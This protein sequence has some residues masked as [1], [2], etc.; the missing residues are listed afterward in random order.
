[1]RE[2]PAFSMDGAARILFF[3]SVRDEGML[4]ALR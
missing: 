3:P 4:M 2:S 1:M